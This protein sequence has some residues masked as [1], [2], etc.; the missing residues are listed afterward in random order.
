MLQPLIVGDNQD[1]NITNL[2]NDL[3]KD[4]F[5][6]DI[7]TDL[8]S[9][10]VAATD[11]SIYEIP[12]KMLLFPRY[13]RDISII[14]KRLHTPSY[15]NYSITARGGSTGTNG[16]SLNDGI[17]ID[18]SRYFN[19]IIDID[20][21]SKRVKV[22]AGVVLEQLNEQLAKL[23][24]F[25]PVQISTANRATIGGMFSTDASGKGSKV[26]GKM[27]ANVAGVKF[28][29][30]LGDSYYWQAC[31][32]DSYLN[33]KS[34]IWQKELVHNIYNTYQQTKHLFAKHF[35]QMNRGLTGYNLPGFINNQGQINLSAL[36]C[37]SEGTLGMVSEV[38]L[39][40]RPLPAYKAVVMVFYDNFLDALSQAQ[41][42]GKFNPIAIESIDETTTRLALNDSS[43]KRVSPLLRDDLLGKIKSFSIVEFAGDNKSELNAQLV[44]F[45]NYL[46][47][48]LNQPQ[49][50]LD[51]H[52]TK[53]GGEI[54]DIWKIRSR[55][56]GLLSSM[57]GEQKPI[58]FVEDCAVSP[59]VLVDFIKEFRHILQNQGYRYGM[60]GHVDVGCIHVRPALNMLCASER[61]QIRIISD[62]VQALVVKYKGIIWGEHGKGMRSEYLVDYLD[63][64]LYAG[65]RDI[66]A[67]FDPDDKFNPGKLYRP[68]GSTD[69]LYGIDSVAIKGK[70]N[71]NLDRSKYAQFIKILDCD[72]NGECLSVSKTD[73]MC[74]SLK[75][76]ANKIHSPKGRAFI[77]REWLHQ[78]AK[79]GISLADG[80]KK[81][82]LLFLGKIFKFIKFNKAN[83]IGKG[84][85]KDFNKEVF[86][87]LDGC[88]SC[89]ACTSLC[90]VRIDI[91][92]Y[93]ARFLDWYYTLYK[94]PYRDFLVASLESVLP[95]MAS[96]PRLVNSLLGQHILAALIDKTLGLVDLPKLSIPT[97][98]ERLAKLD[99]SLISEKKSKS[100]Y[101]A[102]KGKKSEVSNSIIIVPDVFLFF[103]EVDVLIAGIKLLKRIGYK[104]EIAN[105]SANGKAQHIKGYLGAFRK[106][107]KRHSK[108]IES[109]ASGGANIISIE[110]SVGL[111]YREEYQV[112][113]DN[114]ENPVLMIEEFLISEIKKDNSCFNRFLK[115]INKSNKQTKQTKQTKQGEKV[116][117]LFSHC[118]QMSSQPHS[119]RSWQKIFEQFTIKLN[120]ESVGCCG[121]AGIFG[122][123]SHHL[124]ESKAIFHY[125]WQ[126]PI[127]EAHKNGEH[128]LASGYSCRHQVRRLTNVDVHHPLQILQDFLK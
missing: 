123:E 57:E 20:I 56:V 101:L 104:V 114:F 90:P 58:A 89:K 100:Y 43:W 41:K 126:E 78:L 12:P 17:V 72:G 118:S 102:N 99:L 107:A 71:A 105:F 70:R 24:Y 125:S 5:Q 92:E 11:N 109:L 64:L 53:H 115:S 26:Y 79:R 7:E 29:N 9:I 113:V 91:P 19:T 68:T 55:G 30:Y 93:K 2:K 82:R 47:S 21:A 84:G 112:Y 27:S 6:G 3:A 108:F 15:K 121:M 44:N 67:C 69:K 74:P 127:L 51:F 122:H 37:G 96:F 34:N 76:S 25:F 45:K 98:K 32:L 4:G 117:R 95:L 54:A 85:K 87:S 111:T 48:E 39:H 16:Q 46:N 31:S 77:L 62:Q 81:N 119:A 35:P 83:K 124:A 97:I 110:P 42:I 63:D 38:I 65:M 128:I 50:A 22:Q 52:I 73:L 75:V 23:G 10:T 59:A 66:K 40:I 116:Y 120:L 33:D 86:S 49:G 36:L 14:L 80:D 60:Y 94:R 8:A 103:Y 88:L 13:E 28:W 1:V 61:A 18:F 106:T